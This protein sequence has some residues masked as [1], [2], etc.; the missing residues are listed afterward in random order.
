MVTGNDADAD[1]FLRFRYV[2]M[3]LGMKGTDMAIRL[4]G[5]AHDTSVWKNERSSEGTGGTYV[6]SCQCEC[7]DDSSV[8][9]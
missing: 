5:R 6:A 8:L 7:K 1:V 9:T 3:S 4:C 2:D